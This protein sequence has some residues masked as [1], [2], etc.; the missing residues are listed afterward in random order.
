[1]QKIDGQRI[2]FVINDELLKEVDR[3]AKRTNQ[4]RSEMMR[5]MLSLGT[6]IFQMYESVGVIKMF[7]V[8]ERIKK[9]VNRS[10]GQQGLF[11]GS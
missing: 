9:T 5:N 2:N 10:V 4:T 11:N 8:S 3:I 7:E 1:M 6:E